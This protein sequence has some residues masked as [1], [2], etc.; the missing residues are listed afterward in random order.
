MHLLYRKYTQ[1]T[2]IIIFSVVGVVGVYSYELLYAWT[3]NIEI[4]S[5]GKDVLFLYVMGNGILTITAFTYYLQFAYGQMKMLVQY[6]T[7]QALIQLPI[8]I[9]S[10]Y[11]FG[12][13]G[14]AITWFVFKFISIIIWVPI[15]HNRFAK[16]IHK[17]WMLKDVMPILIGSLL[18]LFIVTWLGIS[19]DGSR[20]EIF[21]ILVFIGLGMLLVNSLVSSEGRRLI[22]N[23]FGNKND[24]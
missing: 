19:F 6:N 24:R 2:S 14:V 9:W 22:L 18:Y 23:K 3:G 20:L 11:E 13:I 1:F 5:F 21:M 15:V 8:M 17:D 10:A 7:I 16:G 4:A 12:A